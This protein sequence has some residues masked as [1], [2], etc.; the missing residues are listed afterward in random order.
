MIDK[1]KLMDDT[2]KNLI[3][4][5]NLYCITSKKFTKSSNI[6]VKHEIEGKIN[7]YF[8]YYD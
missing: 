5:M 8:S 6:K 1:F 2:K 3:V 4:K 7:L